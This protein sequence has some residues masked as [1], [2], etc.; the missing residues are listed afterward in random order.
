MQFLFVDKAAFSQTVDEG[1]EIL[2]FRFRSKLR[3]VQRLGVGKFGIGRTS[4]IERFGDQSSELWFVVLRSGDGSSA[5]RSDKAV[6]F[7]GHFVRPLL[8][9]VANGQMLGDFF[10]SGLVQSARDIPI[11]R[12][13][14]GTGGPHGD[15]PGYDVDVCAQSEWHWLLTNATL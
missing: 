10:R 14:I 15:T 11:Q 7:A 6:R 8:T 13:D 4:N 9:T 12:D 3:I 2:A 5:N 1:F